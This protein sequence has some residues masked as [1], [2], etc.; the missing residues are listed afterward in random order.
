MFSK[1][2]DRI[3]YYSLMQFVYKRKFKSYG[4]N[5]TWGKHFA[6]RCIPSSVRISCP[7]KIEIGDH[8]KI[9]EG[10]YLQCHWQG[11]GIS[12]GQGVRINAHTHILSFDKITLEDKVLIA[13]FCLLTSGNHGKSLGHEAIMDTAHLPSGAI[14]IGY[15][16]WLGH[17]S[18]IMGG[19]SLPRC[20]TV[21]S[22]A[23]VTK[24]IDQEGA[25]VAG[26]PASILSERTWT[27]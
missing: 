27:K 12:I 1:L 10:V 22:S 6:A 23:V 25:V 5:I 11:E 2:I 9:D 15:G 17:G 13:P 21:A 14:S 3:A 4:K 19:V 20:T 26:I 24:S 18:K 7:Q 8:C 16:S